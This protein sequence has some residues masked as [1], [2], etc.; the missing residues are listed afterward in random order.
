VDYNDFDPVKPEDSNAD[1]YVML[2][3]SHVISLLS[4]ANDFFKSRYGMTISE[5]YDT[6]R[7]LF[8]NN[9]DVRVPC[10]GLAECQQQDED[11][12]RSVLVSPSPFFRSRVEAFLMHLRLTRYHGWKPYAGDQ[13]TPMYVPVP[14]EV[15][16]PASEVQV[17][18][19]P[20]VQLTPYPVTEPV[21]DPVVEP[22]TLAGMGFEP[23]PVKVV[24]E[25]HRHEETMVMA[26]NPDPGADPEV[27]GSPEHYG[28]DDQ[29][30]LSR[31]RRVRRPDTQ[32]PIRDD[33]HQQFAEERARDAS[34]EEA[35]LQSARRIRD[36][37][38]ASVRENM[39]KQYS[40]PEPPVT[41]SETESTHAFRHSGVLGLGL[42]H[43]SRATTTVEEET[44][45]KETRKVVEEKPKKKRRGLFEGAG[46]SLKAVAMFALLVVAA[47][48][49][50]QL[51]KT[52]LEAWRNRKS[53]QAASATVAPSPSAQAEAQA[54]AMAEL[55][56]TP[57]TKAD[58]V[59]LDRRLNDRVD[60]VSNSVGNRLSSVE[61]RVTVLETKVNAKPAVRASSSAA[62]A[63]PLTTAK[64]PA[65][66]TRRAVVSQPCK[67][68]LWSYSKADPAGS[69]KV[70]PCKQ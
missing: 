8:L 14:P 34:W 22:D 24:D 7:V 56:K 28:T 35:D 41:E 30:D 26:V 16:E 65:T 69:V 38:E 37:L 57:A 48:L 31:T 58:I 20:Q 12:I 29:F 59:V 43:D 60:A 32:D 44:T 46:N 53:A 42:D 39:R 45:V 11:I 23:V 18:E 52:G 15:S 4:M 1:E 33:Y 66:P 19:E 61:H 40:V 36:E 21:A 51:G 70:G 47:V 49:L 55:A 3:E 50:Y 67:K 13:E 9:L 10:S 54:K 64:K 25:V 5:H 27:M 62:T 68:I 63:K 2:D 17:A 6:M